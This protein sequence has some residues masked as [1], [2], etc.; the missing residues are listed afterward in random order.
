MSEPYKEKS[1]LADMYH[2]QNMS[3]REIAD[4]FN[5][6][7]SVIRYWMQKF[8]I[9]RRSKSDA[10]KIRHSNNHKPWKNESQLL[11]E[12]VENEKSTY[13]LA[14]QWGC[15]Q[16]TI[17]NWL[18]RFDIESR[19]TGDYLSQGYVTLKQSSKGQLTWQDY[20]QPSRGKIMRVSRL[21]AVSEF[22]IDAVKGKVVHHRNGIPWDN[23]PEN[24]ELL[25]PSEHAKHHYEKGDLALDPYNHIDELK[26]GMDE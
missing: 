22:G 3:Q 19:D 2:R 6:T 20:S 12:Y 10:T 9:P 1:T 23:R 5:V 7:R 15:D 4:Y 24:L 18:K 13:E 14:N 26:G 11:K 16:A 21:V 25:T 8:D 17:S